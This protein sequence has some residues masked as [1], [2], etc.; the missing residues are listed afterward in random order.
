MIQERYYQKKAAQQLV[1]TLNQ[2][3][4]NMNIL[5]EYDSDCLKNSC[6]NNCMKEKIDISDVQIRSLNC[7]AECGKIEMLEINANNFP[8]CKISSTNKE[9][10]CPAIYKCKNPIIE[11]SIEKCP[12]SELQEYRAK[13]IK[14]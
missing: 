14:K 11:G 4:T 13:C 5:K 3:D 1:N 6:A 12:E 10:D 8:Q 7:N 2:Y 9:P